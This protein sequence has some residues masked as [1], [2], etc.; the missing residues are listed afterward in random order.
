MGAALKTSLS[1]FIVVIYEVYHIGKTL[2][3]RG[4]SEGTCD[5]LEILQSVFKE[6]SAK[7]T[8]TTEKQ[9]HFIGTVALLMDD[10]L[11]KAGV[12]EDGHLNG[13]TQKRRP[14]KPASTVGCPQ[15]GSAPKLGHSQQNK[16][17]T[18]CKQRKSLYMVSL[19]RVPQSCS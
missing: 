12:G 7:T 13:A 5:R 15:T 1:T 8:E 16:T 3:P 18:V 6:H 2:K 9:G 10:E 17:T 4:L 14:P 19:S 11:G